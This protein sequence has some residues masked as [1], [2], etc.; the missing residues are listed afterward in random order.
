MAKIKRPPLHRGLR[1]YAG[2]KNGIQ[3]RINSNKN[4]VYSTK[5]SKHRLT[6][7]RAFPALVKNHMP[8][9]VRRG[10]LPYANL[11]NLRCPINITIKQ[12]NTKHPNLEK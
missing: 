7:T 6:K 2:G 4:V 3:Q 8:A 12:I 11:N 1:M 5:A 10:P 9:P